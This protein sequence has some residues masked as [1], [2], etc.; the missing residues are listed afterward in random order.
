MSELR[1]NSDRAPEHGRPRRVFVAGATGYIGR[2]VALE[3]SARGHQVVCFVREHSGIGA[4]VGPDQ[5]RR[6]LA[7]CEVRFGNV[8]Q[9]RSLIED[10]FRGEK[11]DAV[12]CCLASRNG[13]VEDSW[14]IDYAASRKL[15]EVSRDSGVGHFILLSAICV[16]KPRLAFQRAKLRMEEELVSSGMTYSV[17]RPTAFFKSLAGQV[18][19]LKQ[20]RPFVLFDNDEA[21]CKPIGEADLAAFMADCLEDSS[22]HN[23]ILPVG[24]P[25]KAV[26]ARERADMLFRLLGRKPRYRRVPIALFDGLIPVLELL[27]RVFPRFRDRAEFARIGRYYATESMLVMDQTSGAYDA[28]ATPSWGNQ[29]LLD[30]YRQVLEDGLTGQELGDHSLFAGLSRTQES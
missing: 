13:G 27:A 8:T 25:G 26:T 5:A 1:L 2:H 30:F 16:Q 28:D 19:A 29:T 4:T 15:L 3:L 6:N 10:G 9:A 17:V 14:R 7:G 21:A 23:R 20:G 12:V 24:G 11:F 18:E 22:R